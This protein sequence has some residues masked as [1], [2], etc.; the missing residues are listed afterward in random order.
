MRLSWT[1]PATA[2]EDGCSAARA[3][4]FCGVFD[5]GDEEAAVSTDAV[6]SCRY[7]R[8]CLLPRELLRQHAEAVARPAGAA[9][10]RRYVLKGLTTWLQTK[11][12]GRLE[13]SGESTAHLQHK[14]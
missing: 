9:R 2:A 1:P 4:A 5:Y 13:L 8:V 10:R 7:K 11:A 12:A 3:E 6:S 14:L